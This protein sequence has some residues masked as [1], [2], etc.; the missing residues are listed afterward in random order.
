MSKKKNKIRGEK[1]AFD[2]FQIGDRI[3]L[4]GYD[5]LYVVTG[6][7]T[8]DGIYNEPTLS[9]ICVQD[10]MGIVMVASDKPRYVD[11]TLKIKVVE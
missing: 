5:E 6:V 7:G 3:V 8:H 9:A 11:D 1:M 2:L 10:G 4:K